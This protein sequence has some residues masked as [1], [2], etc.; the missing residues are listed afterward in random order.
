MPFVNQA[1]FPLP[2]ND[3]MFDWAMNPAAAPGAIIP[4]TTVPVATLPMFTPDGTAGVGPGSGV[5]IISSTPYQEANSL[6]AQPLNAP[7]KNQYNAI[8]DNEAALLRRLQFARN[9]NG[10]PVMGQGA[11]ASGVV[12]LSINPLVDMPPNA[13]PFDFPGILTTPAPG[14][15]DSVVLSFTVP[16][17]WDGVVKALANVYTGPGFVEGSGDLIWRLRV[18]GQY[19][20]NYDSIQTTLGS[21]EEPRKIEGGIVLSSGQLVE[22]LVTVA[23]AA[24]IPT[25]AGTQIV[26]FLRGFFY[27]RS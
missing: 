3:P 1:Y 22:Y 25:G 19:V 11:N 9:P 21:F 26:C 14:T 23:A 4:A 2:F 12:S 10:T 20:K 5:P 27:P 18:N 6:Y 24:S 16:T 7:P 15:A 17:G 13:A 8:L